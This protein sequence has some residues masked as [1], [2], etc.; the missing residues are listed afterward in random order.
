MVRGRRRPVQPR[1][2]RG[3]FGRSSS[4]SIP[5][6]ASVYHFVESCRKSGDF[7]RIEESFPKGIRPSPNGRQCFF[8]GD[9]RAPYSMLQSPVLNAGSGIYRRVNWKGQQVIVQRIDDGISGEN[10]RIVFADNDKLAQ[11]LYIEGEG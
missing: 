3:F 10:K 5:R 1:D 11:M 6:F 8:N 4:H 2:W 9:A 7:G